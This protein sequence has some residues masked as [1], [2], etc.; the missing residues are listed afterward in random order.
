VYLLDTKVAHRY[1]VGIDG[2]D[3]GLREMELVFTEGFDIRRDKGELVLVDD[4]TDD[5]VPIVSGDV[6]EG[7]GGLACRE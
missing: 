7:D 2:F 5:A 1:R 6:L 3:D 4:K